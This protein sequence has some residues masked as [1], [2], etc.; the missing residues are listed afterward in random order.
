MARRA[1]RGA[2]NRPYARRQDHRANEEPRRRQNREEN[3]PEEQ[4]NRENIVDVIREAVRQEG[5]RMRQEFMLNLE[6]VIRAAVRYE[7]RAEL[8]RPQLLQRFRQALDDE[9]DRLI[10]NE[11]PPE[12][13]AA[14]LEN[15]EA[16]VIP[17]NPAHG[18]DPAK[19]NEPQQGE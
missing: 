12:N 7:L 9:I 15:P 10:V 17:E 13:A 2:N 19:E 5:I 14:D 6:D 16:R 18:D 8:E 1:N 4:N 11:D 3:I